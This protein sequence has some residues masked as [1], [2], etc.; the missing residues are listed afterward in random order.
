MAD[1]GSLGVVAAARLPEW[2]APIAEGSPS[3][4]M[5]HRAGLASEGLVIDRE[6]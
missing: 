4:S 6:H 1:I 5:L 3:G 2:P